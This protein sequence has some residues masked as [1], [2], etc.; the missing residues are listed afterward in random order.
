VYFI[1]YYSLSFFAKKK[2][3]IKQQKTQYSQKKKKK[4][5]PFSD[6]IFPFLAENVDT[7]LALSPE[8]PKFHKT[9]L[10]KSVSLVR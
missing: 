1:Y 3:Q 6:P 4:C 2:N 10:L 5:N 8:T 7:D 9:T